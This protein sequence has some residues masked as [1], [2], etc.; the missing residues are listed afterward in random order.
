MDSRHC[1]LS[2]SFR[3]KKEQDKQRT[4]LSKLV[5]IKEVLGH[6][7]IHVLYTLY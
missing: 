2:N 5:V 3:T 1:Q 6:K 4:L 7:A